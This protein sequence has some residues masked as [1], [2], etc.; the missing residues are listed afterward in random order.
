MAGRLLTI[1]KTYF[2]MQR[3]NI[4]CKIFCLFLL[5]SQGD[6]LF[7]QIE[8]KELI[9]SRI[10]IPPKIDGQ[11]DDEA[12]QKAE[13]ATDFYQY[14]PFNDRGASFPTQV[15]LVYD[16]NAIYIGARLLDPSPDSILT[17]L[18]VRDADSE[19]NADKFSI[20]ISPFNDGVNGFTFKVSAS[21]VQ[22]DINRSMSTVK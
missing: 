15:Y 11:L 18:G 5:I 10:D 17:E 20:D 4:I 21:G 1:L 3:R 22:T 7:G 2:F 14:R 19:M 6:F 12:W 13:P 16:D 9:S 8:R